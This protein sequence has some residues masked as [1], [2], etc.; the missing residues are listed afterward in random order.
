[1]LEKVSQASI[2]ALVEVSDVGEIVAKHV[3]SFFAEPHNTDVVNALIEQGVHWPELTPPSEESQPLVGLTYVLT[4]TL[5]E[6]NRNDAKARLQA[7]GAKV[8]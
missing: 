5:N 7:L 6:L 4:G 1:T 3:N 2:E 8:S